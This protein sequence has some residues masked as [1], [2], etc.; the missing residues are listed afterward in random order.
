MNE[1]SIKFDYKASGGEIH[2]LNEFVRELKNDY[3]LNARPNG[4]PQS[5]GIFDVF[6]EF[7]ANI[8]LKD[9]VIGAI[10][11]GM[12]WDGVKI[13]TRKFLFKPIFEAFEKLESQNE[14][15]DY[16]PVMKIKFDDVELV[17]YGLDRAF[18]ININKVFNILFKHFQDIIDLSSEKLYQIHIPAYLNDEETEREVYEVCEYFDTSSINY[19]EFWAMSYMLDHHRDVLDVQNLKLLDRDW[20]RFG[21]KFKSR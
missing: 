16:W 8:T 15:L 2:G 6:V 11:G 9:F 18:Y 1:I 20:Q 12:L 13:G 5:G 17:F 14:L 7:F 21:S 3:I 4:L 19:D 10:A